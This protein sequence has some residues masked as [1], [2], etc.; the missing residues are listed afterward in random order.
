VEG[1]RLYWIDRFGNKEP[2][3]IGTR[4]FLAPSLS[5]RGDRVA[6]QIIEPTRRD[7]FVYDLVSGAMT[8]VTFDGTSAGP[9][10]TPDGERLVF[11]STKD[12]PR[13]LYWQP[14]NGI[15]PPE[16]LVADDHSLWAGSW[17]PDGRTL[18]YV[19]SS[20]TGQT[21]LALVRV[22]EKPTIA[23]A[24]VAA[25]QWPQISPDGR[26][27]AYVSSDT[28]KFEVYV[29]PLDDLRG[30]RQLSTDGG[31]SPRWSRDGRELFFRSGDRLM[32]VPVDTLPA[33]TPRPTAL[34]IQM[35]MADGTAAHPGYDI[36]PDG[37]RL[38][39]VERADEEAAPPRLFV[40]LNWLEELK[41]RV[42]TR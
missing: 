27:L 23:V 7:I 19:R 2:L 25:D 31:A 4:G 15:G 1:R 29:S 10:W 40:V 18:A 36:S 9:I 22:G 6:L 11:S 17:S 21:D 35:R 33:T 12:G 32:V 14:A 41:Q 13:Q 28:G 3:A 37:R 34:P 39:V 20:P 42:P 8:R 24:N 38:I 5:P 30:K 26:W 16:L